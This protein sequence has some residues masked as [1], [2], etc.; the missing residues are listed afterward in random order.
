MIKSQVAGVLSERAARLKLCSR[1]RSSISYSRT[2]NKAGARK[3]RRV[4]WAH[5]I[6]FKVVGAIKNGFDNLQAHH[7]GGVVLIQIS[8]LSGGGGRRAPF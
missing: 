3:L 8:S 2:G 6:I 1:Y 5:L 4:T 7:I